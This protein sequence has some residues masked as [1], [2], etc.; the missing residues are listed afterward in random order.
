MRGFLDGGE[1]IESL[2]SPRAP[3][4]HGY[5]QLLAC[6]LV[7]VSSLGLQIQAVFLKTYVIY[8]CLPRLL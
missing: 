1:A 2:P 3:L 4:L 8:M 6:P 7:S 5:N